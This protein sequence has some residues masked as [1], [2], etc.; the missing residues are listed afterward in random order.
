[1]WPRQPRAAT[2]EETLTGSDADKAAAAAVTEVG[3]EVLGVEAGDN[4]NAAYE[5]EVKPATGEVE[6]LVDGHFRG[7][8]SQG[9]DTDA[10]EAANVRPG[11]RLEPGDGTRLGSRLGSLPTTTATTRD[12]AGPAVASIAVFR[13]KGS[14]ATLGLPLRRHDRADGRGDGC[15]SRQQRIIRA[16]AY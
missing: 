3:G 16:C 12:R 10:N 7:D 1:M 9:D 4:G 11:P 15:P 14:P 13:M 2:L 8:P 6:V 5:V